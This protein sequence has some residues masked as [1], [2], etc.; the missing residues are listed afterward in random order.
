MLSKLDKMNENSD[1]NKNVNFTS[2]AWTALSEYEKRRFENVQKNFEILKASGITPKMP[3]FLMR[4]FKRPQSKRL[5]MDA[6][7]AQPKVFGTKY[8]LDVPAQKTHFKLFGVPQQT[9][10]RNR[11]CKQG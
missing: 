3:E 8:A 9:A 5:K 10:P 2:D 4:K 6:D 7:S 1:R 11:K